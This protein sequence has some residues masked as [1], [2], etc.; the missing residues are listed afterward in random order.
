MKYN[1]SVQYVTSFL[2][3]KVNLNIQYLYEHER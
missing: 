2:N 3:I 1:N